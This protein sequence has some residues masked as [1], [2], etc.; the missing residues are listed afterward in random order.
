MDDPSAPVL[1]ISIGRDPV[2]GHYEA[3]STRDFDQLA[4]RFAGDVL[5]RLSFAP[6]R[7]RGRTVLRL[8]GHLPAARQRELAA[9]ATATLRLLGHEVRLSPDLHGIDAQ[10]ALPRAR[11]GKALTGL[12]AE[13]AQAPTSD[14]V[15]RLLLELTAPSTGLLPAAAN[16]LAAAGRWLANCDP[17]AVDDHAGGLAQAAEQLR[18]ITTQVATAQAHTAHLDRPQYPGQV[19][20]HLRP[21]PARST[22]AAVPVPPRRTH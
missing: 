22:P 10:P 1:V 4:D 3:R 8:P 20:R 9:T 11:F 18:R 6:E 2:T 17:S 16:A 7:R 21:V 13:V 14:E 12:S 19:R 15:A 5:Q